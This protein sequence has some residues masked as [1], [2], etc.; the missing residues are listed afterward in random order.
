MRILFIIMILSGLFVPAF[1]QKAELKK[2]EAKAFFAHE[3]YVEALAAL[4]AHRKMLKEDPEAQLLAAVSYYQTNQLEDAMAMLKL[5]TASDEAPYPECWLY[6]GKVYHAMHRFEKAATYYKL[7][8]KSVS[9][10]HP[11]RQAVKDNI[12]RCSNGI[13]WLFRPK[14][15]EVDNLGP[16]VNTIGDEYRPV[17]SPNRVERLYF[18]AIRNGNVG[19]LRNEYG[20]PDEAYGRSY[21]DIFST[22]LQSGIWM[23]AQPMGHL[24][25]S[26]RHERLVDF[27]RAGTAMYFY[28]G[29]KNDEGQIFIDSFSSDQSQ[30]LS[31][32]PFM[33]P[34]ATERGDKDLFFYNDTLIIFSSNRLKG[35]G[36]YDLFKISFKNGTWSEPVNLGETVNSP[37]DEISPY[38]SRNGL[39]L[40]YS[41]N[42]PQ[43]SMGGFDIVKTVYNSRKNTWSAPYNLG[44]PINSAGDD[45]HFR[46]APNGFTAY[47][48]SSRKESRGKRDIYGAYFDEFLSEMEPPVVSKYMPPSPVN[49]PPPSIP[50]KEEIEID[51]VKPDYQVPRA[52]ESIAGVY[53]SD[54][55]L[56]ILEAA[57]VLLKQHYS[58]TLVLSAY[59]PSGANIFAPIKKLETMASDLQ[60]LGVGVDQIFM[61]SIAS[62]QYTTTSFQLSINDVT[63]KD[64]VW[65]IH[66]KKD[67]IWKQERFFKVQISSSTRSLSS[68]KSLDAYPVPMVEKTPEFK[69]YRYTLGAF[70]SEVE[71]KAYSVQL[72]KEGFDGAYVVE[73]IHG[74][75]K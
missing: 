44:L 5:M 54:I 21:S 28:K 56:D 32:T 74:V 39:A 60:A 70:T 25:N 41:T 7:F 20:Q 72:R 33:S 1:S 12:V 73:Y 37:Y 15:A 61:R 57:A 34:I 2:K 3:H 11:F 62:E 24:V 8:L 42:L 13:S 17:P 68:S 69:Y 38:L 71:A 40:Y 16:L 65:G 9:D 22:H 14:L 31:S 67:Q 27:N 46:L 19:G 30:L 59:S 55:P 43:N 49:N 29:W 66:I 10:N 52:V 45:M 51:P 36:G 4:H 23:Q 48:A 6:M 53:K 58:A 75:R 50:E 47:F 26:P 64:A 18:T 63:A 35:Y